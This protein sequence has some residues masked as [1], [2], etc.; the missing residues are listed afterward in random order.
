GGRAG[1]TGGSGCTARWPS[2]RGRSRASP[3]AAGSSRVGPSSPAFW[4]SAA[5]WT[6]RK[7][8]WRPIAGGTRAGR[9]HSPPCWRSPSGAGRRS[10]PRPN[11]L[12]M[13]PA[14][15][16]F[17]TQH[18]LLLLETLYDAGLSLGALHH[19]QALVEDVLGRALRLP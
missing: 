18:K 9:L 8:S 16:D 11:S 2:P 7:S 6:A 15:R 12:R 3:S 17:Q 14:V 13:E 10:W 5:T 1:A 19:E 4:P